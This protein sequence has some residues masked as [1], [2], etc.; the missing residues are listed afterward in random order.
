[1]ARNKLE[2]VR[3]HLF[4]ALERLNEEGMTEEQVVNETRKA[5]SIA[6]LSSAI[7]ETAKLEIS[8][9]KETGANK[10][11][12]RLFKGLTNNNLIE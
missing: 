8:F 12:S 3:D 2:D 5:K 1:M 6:N 7:V 9:L 4:M 11:S 10:T